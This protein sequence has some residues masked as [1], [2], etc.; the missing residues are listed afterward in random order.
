[1]SN[2]FLTLTHY[3]IDGPTS[4]W[5]IPNGGNTG[6]GNMLFQISSCIA[7]AIKNNATLYVPGLETF[8]KVEKLE[9]RNTIFRN[10]NSECPDEY[11]KV[12][13]N[14]IMAEPQKN[15][16]DYEFSNNMNFHTYFEN[17]RN[18]QDYRNV[19]LDTFRPSTNDFEYIINKYPLILEDNICSIHVRLGP[20]YKN[21]FH[22]NIDRLKE[23]EESYF[24]CIDHMISE[25]NIRIFFVFTNDKNYCIHIL[26]NNP[27]YNNIRF[28]YSEERD[29]VDVWM[30]SLIKNNITSVSTLAWWGSFLNERSDKYILCCKG[31]RDDLHYNGWI[32]IFD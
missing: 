3:S 5:F 9:K 7:F 11:F 32:T 26:N 27:K 6:I 19:I 31:C 18:F 24:K 20:D 8:F 23:L 25:K 30:I 13:D 10:I 29:Y 12:K 21:I 4:P 2:L 16:W 14:L 28:V 17:Y 1:M 15:I 22:R